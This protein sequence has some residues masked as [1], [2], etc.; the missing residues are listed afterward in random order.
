MT[1]CGMLK[2]ASLQNDLTAMVRKRRT[3]HQV[4]S[5]LFEPSVVATPLILLFVYTRRH[6]FSLDLW[7]I[8]LILALFGG[9]IPLLYTY[10]LRSRN[11]ISSFSYSRRQDRVF[12]YPMLLV[13]VSSVFML[14]V[15]TSTSHVLLA[16]AFAAFVAAAGLMMLT[17]W[18]KISYHLAGLGG[19]MAI[20][21]ALVGLP[22]FALLPVMFLV[23]YSRRR[24][25]E[26]TWL[27]V[28]V[29]GV[30]GIVSAAAAYRWFLAHGDWVIGRL[31]GLGA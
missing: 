22:G 17:L 21:V 29:G 27:E 3:L 19:I 4:I 6:T 25:N 26:H 1:P 28:G 18:H 30:Y 13:C 8:Y 9:V 11:Y 7:S 15:Y 20:T 10:M 31:P 5:F 12:F 24:L 2:T 16:A 14:F 23:A